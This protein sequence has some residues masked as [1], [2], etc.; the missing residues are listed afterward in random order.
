MILIK[1]PLA[2]FFVPTSNVNFNNSG[3][4]GYQDPSSDR[5]VLV[6]ERADV[7]S[8]TGTLN[9]DVSGTHSSYTPSSDNPIH[10]Y[11]LFSNDNTDGNSRRS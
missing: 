10:V 11:M 1:S 6:Q 8:G 5:F 4:G 9:F 2:P 3:S 7:T